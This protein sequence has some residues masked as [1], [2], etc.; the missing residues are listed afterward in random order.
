MGRAARDEHLPL[1]VDVDPFEGFDLAP[2]DD[3]AA[4]KAM[5][6]R[7]MSSISP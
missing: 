1:F 7:R 2:F 4:R 5:V 3:D 6:A